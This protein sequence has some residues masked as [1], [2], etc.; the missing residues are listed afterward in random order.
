VNGGGPLT[1]G[2]LSAAVQEAMD[3]V[4]FVFLVAVAQGRL[5][6]AV[7]SPQWLACQHAFPVVLSPADGDDLVFAMPR[8][9]CG[10]NELTTLDPTRHRIICSGAETAL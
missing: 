8:G 2:S 5:D 3:L 10:T 1:I 7:G 9:P 6:A 4:R